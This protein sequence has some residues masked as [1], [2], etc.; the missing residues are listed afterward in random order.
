VGESAE[1]SAESHE[2]IESADSRGHEPAELS[3][4]SMERSDESAELSAD[5]GA[6]ESALS[7]ESELSAEPHVGGDVGHS[8][9]DPDEI[10]GRVMAGE[11]DVHASGAEPASDHDAGAGVSADAED[12][13]PVHAA[14]ADGGD[15]NESDGADA[16][17][18][19]EPPVD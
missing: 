5:A 11:S 13:E 12:A 8:F 2:P 1:L 19:D 4:E 18:N 15:A 7:D 10:A 3:A 14:H 6:D 17:A 16:S 9:I